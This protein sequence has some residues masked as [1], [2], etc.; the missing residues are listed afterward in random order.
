MSTRIAQ[1]QGT[2]IRQ[3]R[4][5]ALHT[6][7]L[8]VARGS[9]VTP[10][11]RDLDSRRDRLRAVGFPTG[12]EV[13][14]VVVPAVVGPCSLFNVA[15]RERPLPG[16]AKERVALLWSG[17]VSERGGAED[18][19]EVVRPTY[20]VRLPRESI[21]A[22]RVALDV[23]EL[24]SGEPAVATPAMRRGADDERLRHSINLMLELFGECE[25]MVDPPL[26]RG[27]VE[28]DLS[29]TFRALHGASDE[30]DVLAAPR[31]YISPERRAVAD[32]RIAQVLGIGPD[33]VAIGRAGLGG[34]IVFGFRA[35]GRV[36]VENLHADRGPRVRRRPLGDSLRWHAGDALAPDD[37]DVRIE[38]TAGWE[39]RLRT[40]V[41][42]AA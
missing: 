13:G 8:G 3:R 35:R 25:L 36:V 30:A 19:H 12:G 15:G 11:L 1:G 26:R 38:Y 18:A 20:R 24:A 16:R 7:L 9:L 5:G 2:T 32:Y 42:G 4:I 23:V 10:L 6:H 33:V 37:D 21:P 29:W 34:L 17:V 22:P 31:A 27:G 14:Q 39:S 41:V 40:A 28:E